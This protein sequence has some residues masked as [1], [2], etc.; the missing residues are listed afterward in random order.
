M[1]YDSTWQAHLAKACGR[2][3]YCDRPMIGSAWRLVSHVK[4]HRP[5]LGKKAK[6]A[7][8]RLRVKELK[9]RDAMVQA[10]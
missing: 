9:R 4:P 10:P 3:Y 7:A 1:S 8:K 2:C 5:K 6:R